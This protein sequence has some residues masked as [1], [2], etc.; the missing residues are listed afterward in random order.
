MNDQYTYGQ[1]NSRNLRVD[2]AYQRK[3]DTKR[4][5]QIAEHF[6]PLKV[7]VVKVSHRDGAYWIFDGQHTTAALMTRNGGRDLPI[8]CKIYEGLTQK[9]EAELF[10]RQNEF[11]KKV[12]RNSE[13]KALYAAGDQEVIELKRA[14]ESVG[15]IFDF[16]GSVGTNKVACCDCVYRIFRKTRVSAFINIMRIVKESW[17]GSPESL[18][19]EII[20]GVW[21]LYSTYK[22]QFDIQL[23]IK[24][25]SY[26]NPVE[27]I[28]EGRVYKSYPGAKKYA[29][30]LLQK[31]N[32]KLRNNKLDSSLLLS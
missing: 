18:R 2:P 22:D 9:D 16:N 12:D 23:A 6:N 19:K 27:V 21:E 20:G 24:K 1:I 5:R 8:D 32:S 11:E 30:I 7:D 13:L 28:R 26:V 4:A 17:S 10:A 15:L 29:F 31:Y 3:L 14:I 25:F